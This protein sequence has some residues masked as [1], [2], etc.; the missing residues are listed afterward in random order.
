MT[1]SYEV[2]FGDGRASVFFYWDDGAG[3]RLRADLL[4]EAEA[5]EQARTLAG[6]ER[7]GDRRTR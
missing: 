2:C 7:D 6:A 3:R 5:L 1:G 4:T